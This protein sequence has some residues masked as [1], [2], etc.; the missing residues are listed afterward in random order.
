MPQHLQ[1]PS[2]LP[3][4][5]AALPAAQE[6]A[7]PGHQRATMKTRKQ[8]LSERRGRGGE[9]GTARLTGGE[10]AMLGIERVGGGAG[11]GTTVR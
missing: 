10:L 1:Q 6:H 8:V 4:T 11:M 2:A 7:A 3:T 5:Q 9:S